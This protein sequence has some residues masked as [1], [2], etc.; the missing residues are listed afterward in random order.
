MRQDEF[1][2]ELCKGTYEKAWSDEEAK[3]E[4]KDLWSKDPERVDMAIVCDDCYKKFIQWY[5][6]RK[7]L[8]LSREEKK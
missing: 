8:T 7:T 6:S 2:C 5:K 1:R 3:K 4:A